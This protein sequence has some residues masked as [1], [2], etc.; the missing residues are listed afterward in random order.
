MFNA[1]VIDK[2]DAGYRARL[3][4]LDEDRLPEGNVTVQVQWST[5]NYKDGLAIT[6]RSPIVRKFPMV[7]GVD[8]A[9]VVRSSTDPDWKAGDTVLLNG[10]GVGEGHFGGLAQLAR[11]KGDWLVP[12]PA[13]FTARQAMA[14]GTAGYTAM[15]SVLAL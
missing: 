2:D 3:G 1:I 10:W 4:T 8:F 5:L 11:V 14:I 12:I 7:P 6:G 15:L 13:P 9:G